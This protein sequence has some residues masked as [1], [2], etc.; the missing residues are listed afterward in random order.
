[1][2]QLPK[3]NRAT[4][5]ETL[6]YTCILLVN[7]CMSRIRPVLLVLRDQV[8]HVGLCLSELHLVHALTYMIS[9]HQLV[10]DSLA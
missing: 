9:A 2:L 10:G 3:K 5:A 4:G 8:I 7:I 6:Q 1:M